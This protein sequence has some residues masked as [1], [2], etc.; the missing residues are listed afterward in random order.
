MQDVEGGAAE[1]L[2]V[3][4]RK[5]LG[6]LPNFFTA[7]ILL[8]VGVGLAK[9][10]GLISLRVFRALNVDRFW[11][12]AGIREVLIRGG[13]RKPLSVE[14]SRIVYWLTVLIFIVI[15]L[16]ALQIP[17][18]EAVLARFFLYLPNVFV[19][20]LI[21]FAGYLLCN[22]FARA[23]LIGL[24]NSGVRE[25]GL[26]ARA[27]RF[28]IFVFAVTMA[29]EQLDIG[30]ASVLIAFTIMFGGAVLAFAIALGLGGQH[31]V[32]EYLERRMRKGSK[33]DVHH[34][35]HV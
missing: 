15:A 34:I 1:M 5:L 12:R 14:L 26:A 18:I 17:V 8:F 35:D 30:K 29:L 33:D 7:L 11:D 19:A 24:V 3:F 13:I 25:A 22:F 10:L 23:A 16:N 27:V 6:F 32:R 4:F 2:H 21:L 31:Y 20:L 28:A 9:V